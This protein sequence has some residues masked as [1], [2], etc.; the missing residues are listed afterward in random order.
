M[1]MSRFL[2]QDASKPE[3]L[4]YALVAQKAKGKQSSSEPSSQPSTPPTEPD[5]NTSCDQQSPTKSNKD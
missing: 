5:N 4:S 1:S 3:K 2:L